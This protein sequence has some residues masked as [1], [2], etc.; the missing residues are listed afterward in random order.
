MLDLFALANENKDKSKK[1]KKVYFPIKDIFN[2]TAI[3]QIKI[4]A[5]ALDSNPE[6]ISLNFLKFNP[7]SYLQYNKYK[8]NRKDMFILT[9]NYDL[10]FYDKSYK[11]ISSFNNF[12]SL[13]CLL[14]YYIT[15]IGESFLGKASLGSLDLNYKKSDIENE[16]EKETE[17]LNDMSINKATNEALLHSANLKSIK[18]L[19]N[20]NF[21]NIFVIYNGVKDNQANVDISEELKTKLQDI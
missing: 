2:P 15:E 20:E 3:N 16:E 17:S 21:M 6:Y 10:A 1:F 9:F 8:D 14:F 12:M 19:I 5:N 13:T 4:I 11:R 7:N 18:K